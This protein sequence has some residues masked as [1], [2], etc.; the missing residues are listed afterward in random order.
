M[1]YFEI[2]RL[3]PKGYTGIHVILFAHMGKH[4]PL[5]LIGD[6]AVPPVVEKYI[7]SIKPIPPKDMP[8]PPCFNY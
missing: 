6:N 4:T 5:L 1:Y 8:R 2:K 7:K 3:C